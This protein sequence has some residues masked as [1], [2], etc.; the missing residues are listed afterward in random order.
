M[1]CCI[2]VDVSGPVVVAATT[3]ERS[4]HHHVQPYRCVMSA[5]FLSRRDNVD[6]CWPGAW[7]QP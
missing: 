4:Q 3:R 1:S 2:T 7:R 5:N 6:S